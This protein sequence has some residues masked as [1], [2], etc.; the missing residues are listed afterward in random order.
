MDHQFIWNISIFI[1]FCSLFLT[2]LLIMFLLIDS[3]VLIIFSLLKMFEWR[4]N[5]LYCFYILSIILANKYILH[6]RIGTQEKG[7]EY[8]YKAS[9][10]DTTRKTMTPFS[11][12][13]ELTPWAPTLP[14]V[15][16]HSNNLSA[17]AND[18]FERVWPVCGL[19]LKGLRKIILKTLRY[20]TKNHRCY[21]N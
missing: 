2:L 1:V 21:K 6:I 10:K 19:V 16:I 14:N 20:T 17:T 8:V 5:L 4:I 18:L 12:P 15:Q 9:N 13:L 7:V 11:C 3:F